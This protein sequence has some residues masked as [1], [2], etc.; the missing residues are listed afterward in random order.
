MFDRRLFRQARAQSQDLVL[1]I[2]F[3]FAGGLLTIGQAWLLSQVLDQAFLQGASLPAVAPQLGA[4][5]ALSLLRASVAFAGDWVAGRMAIEI[6][7]E[8]RSAL[9]IHLARL[10]PAFTQ[11]ERTGEL[12]NTVVEGVE[13]LDA[14]F[15]QYL[16]QLVIS[17]LVPVSLLVV[18][19]RSDPLSA[20]V[21]A[22]TAPLLPVFMILIGRATEALTRRQYGLLSLLSAHF[23]DVLQGLTTLKALGQSKPQAEVIRRVSER[24]RSATMEVLRV[25]FVSALAL[26]LIATI[27]TAIV[28]VEVGLRLLYGRLPF[29]EAMFI[30]VLAPEFYLPLRNLGA[31]WHAGA[32]GSAAA[33]R[34]FEVLDTPLPRSSAPSPE[35]LEAAGRTPARL[36]ISLRDV[37]YSYDGVRHA[38]RGVYLEIE[39][40]TQ[41]ALVGPSGAGKSTIAH[42]LL[43]FIDP[44]AGEIL[45]D[46]QPLRSL[47]PDSWRRQIA[48]VPQLPH[49]LNDTLAANLRLARPDAAADDLAR[50]V[51]LAHLDDLVASL[52]HGLETEIGEA[53][54]RLSAG[55]AQ[56]LALARAFL[57]DVP[58][59]L[60]DEPTSNVDPSLEAQL[61][62]STDRLMQG[63][64]VLAI[65]HRMNTVYRADQIAVV[66][67]GQVIERG[68]HQHLW[69]AGGLYRQLLA[70]YA[71]AAA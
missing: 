2:A 48:W 59:L 52:P 57:K 47:D 70:P 21:L 68:T 12:A 26:E 60:L 24:Y 62:D 46:G 28:A 23:L 4:L 66:C 6:K 50:A 63:R 8:L 5:L 13:S 44:T 30:L 71:E 22:L 18:I 14:Y 35:S 34:I 27:S 38:L 64:T 56:R 40:G 51:H 65:A 43:R 1:T 7:S 45:V 15:R 25:A 10:G 58:L 36:A 17:A 39:P 37:H 3:S 41:V 16:P 61:V 42:L 11:V 53:G 49:L 32:A 55:Q 9:L 54:A 33:K 20:L 29:Q 31:R 67:Q 19:L 69:Q